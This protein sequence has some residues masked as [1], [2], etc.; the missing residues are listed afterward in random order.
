MENSNAVLTHVTRQ[1]P[2][3]P[4]LSVSANVFYFLLSVSA[5]VFWKLETIHFSFGE[6][7]GLYSHFGSF[8][9]WEPN[10]AQVPVPL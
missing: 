8:L 1:I 9:L 2:I 10:T 3:F 5:I 7:H 4:F 6:M